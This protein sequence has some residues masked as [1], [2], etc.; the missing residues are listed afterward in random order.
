MDQQQVL[1]DGT[2]GGKN[3][4]DLR[5]TLDNKRHYWEYDTVSS[6]RALEH[7]LRIKVNDPDAI[8]VLK[9]AP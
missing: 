5:F 1:K 6:N 8:I 9:T 4:P 3:R 7:Y 2:Q